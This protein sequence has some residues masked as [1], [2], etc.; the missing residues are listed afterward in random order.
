[1]KPAEINALLDTIKS[2]KYRTLLMLV[3][4]SGA[5]KGE[6]LGLKWGE[7]DWISSQISIQRIFNN[8]VW[9]DVRTETSHRKID[10][11]PSMLAELKTWKLACQ[12]NKLDLVFSQ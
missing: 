9:Y 2:Q 6:Q 1:L 12:P 3:I 10:I 7:V 11:G 8:Q 4:M 5:R